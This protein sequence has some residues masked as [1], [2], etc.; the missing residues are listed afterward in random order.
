MK[1]QTLAKV[2]ILLL[3]FNVVC[4]WLPGVSSEYSC[5]WMLV[6]CNGRVCVGVGVRVIRKGSFMSERRH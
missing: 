5:V 2:F 6:S 3:C 1:E 4:E